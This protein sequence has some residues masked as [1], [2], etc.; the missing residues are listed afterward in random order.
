[1]FKT[2]KI[3]LLKIK[4]LSVH[5]WKYLKTFAFSNILNFSYV[6]PRV[7]LSL[8]GPTRCHPT[9]TWRPLIGR[10]IC[11]ICHIIAPI[12]GPS[13]TCHHPAI[14]HFLT[15]AHLH[16]A[17]M[18]GSATWRSSEALWVFGATSSLVDLLHKILLYTPQA[19]V[20]SIW[21]DWGARMSFQK[22]FLSSYNALEISHI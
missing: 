1:M 9:A 10:L 15:G 8:T 12:P 11:F 2:S 17:G 22:L 6:S 18:R 5:I 13:A 20:I 14:P 3:P 16:I 21:S 4:N 7:N 19:D